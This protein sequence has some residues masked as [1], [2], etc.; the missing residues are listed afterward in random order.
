MNV[1]IWFF[2]SCLQLKFGNYRKMVACQPGYPH[3]AA[4]P[5]E[6]F[7]GAAVENLVKT[8]GGG[9]RW[10]GEVGIVIATA[11]IGGTLK[12]KYIGKDGSQPCPPVV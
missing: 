5:F 7:H 4:L 12:V 3:P 9:E 2:N 6:Q 10:V 8:T 11:V 1:F